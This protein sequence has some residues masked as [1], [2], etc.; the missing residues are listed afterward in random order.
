MRHL[1]LSWVPALFVALFR[2]ADEFYDFA[3]PASMGCEFASPQRL[4]R[5]L[6]RAAPQFLRQLRLQGS[7]NSQE[8]VHSSR[9]PCFIHYSRG[10]ARFKLH[11]HIHPPS[12]PFSTLTIFRMVSLPR[13]DSSRGCLTFQSNDSACHPGY[14]ALG[15][16]ASF[17]FKVNLGICFPSLC[18]SP[19]F[20]LSLSSV[21]L[22]LP[23]SL[24]FPDRFRQSSFS[25]FYSLFDERSRERKPFSEKLDQNPPYPTY[26]PILHLYFHRIWLLIYERRLYRRRIIFDQNKHS[27]FEKK[28]GWIF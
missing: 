12:F 25:S 20:S 11:P 19:C 28:S 9:L 27:I 7:T 13:T 5:Q 24:L 18:L 4:H 14:S 16:F 2:G 6:I 10:A 1:D 17:F 15:R 22:P 23:L 21:S 3:L 8:S 26:N